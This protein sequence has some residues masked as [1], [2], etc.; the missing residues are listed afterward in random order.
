MSKKGEVSSLQIEA[1]FAIK[2]GLELVRKLETSGILEPWQL[3][4]WQNLIPEFFL[5]YKAAAAACEEKNVCAAAWATRN[6]LEL[7][8]WLNYCVRSRDCAKRF[9]DDK[10]R[11]IVNFLDAIDG[12]VKLI[13]NPDLATFDLL[14]GT[15]QRIAMKAE[16]DGYE[17]IHGTYQPVHEA[18]QEVG[19][20][21]FFRSTNKLLSKFA[22]PT[23][24][25]V[26]SLQDEPGRS[27]TCA[28]FSVLGTIL[29]ISSMAEFE[30]YTNMIVT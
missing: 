11:D 21:L 27:Q 4:L 15:R 25:I 2:H 18:A 1:V 28:F 10:A 6:L 5:C 9:Y 3:D 7:T 30:K 12:L 29:C 17:D 8:V 19:L 14:E 13:N 24:M 16:L 26:F 20:G 22:H 23:A